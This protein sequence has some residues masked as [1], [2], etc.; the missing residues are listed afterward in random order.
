MAK[1]RINTGKRTHAIRMGCEEGVYNFITDYAKMMGI[2]RSS[3]VRRLLLIGAKCETDHSPESTESF[4]DIFAR[5]V[6]DD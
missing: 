4:D 5:Q 1:Y 3:A 6:F 2:S